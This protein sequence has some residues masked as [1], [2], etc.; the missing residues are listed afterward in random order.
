MCEQSVRCF[1]EIS[2]APERKTIRGVAGWFQSKILS[3]N[4]EIHFGLAYSY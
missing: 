3:S 2:S 4:L 1:T